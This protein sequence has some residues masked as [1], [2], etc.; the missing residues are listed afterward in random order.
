MF[1]DLSNHHRG[2]LLVLFVLMIAAHSLFFVGY[3]VSDDLLY[4]AQAKQYLAGDLTPP[5][6]HWGFRY[7]FVLP[8]TAIGFV[9][10]F[11]ERSLAIFSLLYWI[12]VFWLMA[13][14]LRRNFGRKESIFGGLLVAT[15]PLFVIQ[16]SIAGVDIAEA[17]FLFASF[18]FFYIA[19]TSPNPRSRSYF[20]VGLFVGLAMLTRETAYGFLF[21]LGVFFMLGGYRRWRFYLIGLGGVVAILS[22]EWAYYIVFDQ[23]P[24]YRLNTITQS[25]GGIGIRTGDFGSGSG[26]ISDNRW[27][28]PILAVLINQEF[29]FLFWVAIGAAI[30]LSRQDDPECRQLL[31]YSGVAFLSYFIWIGYSGAIRPLP[32]YFSFP[33]LLAMLPIAL[34]LAKLPRS[35]FRHSILLLLVGG[36]FVAL[37]VENIYP[38]FA[39]R[40]VS[41]YA[42]KTGDVVV[43]DELTAWQAREFLKLHGIKNPQVTDQITEGAPFT[44]AVVEGLT[45]AT[46]LELPLSPDALIDEQE[47]PKLLIG[48]LLDLFGLD[49]LVPVPLYQYLAIRNPTVRFYR[50]KG[51]S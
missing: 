31:R 41:E 17:F 22:L 12:A 46:S 50:V 16:S 19:E 18:V 34:M 2:V 42:L 51:T 20:I 24:L 7:T 11:D 1:H 13:W 29:A 9:A 35:W 47:P 28:A 30:F 49:R 15:L 40:A 32:R 8:L 6:T 38:R 39:A 44:V 27:V 45:P 23:G 4:L 25:H 10:E 43:T 37:S 33:S 36:S 48:R 5:Q 3:I 21:V 14:F 26:N